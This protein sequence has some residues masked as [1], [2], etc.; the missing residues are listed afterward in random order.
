MEWRGNLRPTKTRSG[1]PALPAKQRRSMYSEGSNVDMDWGM[2][3]L[4]SLAGLQLLDQPDPDVFLEGVCCQEAQC[5]LHKGSVSSCCHEDEVFSEGFPPPVPRK[6]LVRAMSMPEGCTPPTAPQR[7]PRPPVSGLNKQLTDLQCFDNPLY[8]LSPLEGAISPERSEAQTAATANPL[9]SSDPSSDTT[10]LSQLSFDTPDEQVLP[11]LSSEAAGVIIAQRHLLF[12]RKAADALESDLLM[13][14]EAGGLSYSPEDFQLCDG[15]EPRQIGDDVY[16]ELHC[17]KFP[18]KVLGARVY[19]PDNHSAHSVPQSPH[20]NLRQVL[21]N[22]SPS[23]TQEAAAQP[24]CT[25][26]MRPLG[27]SNEFVD[28]QLVSPINNSPTI[29]ELLERG[30]AVSVERDFPQATLG[31][32]FQGRCAKQTSD[33]ALYAKQLCLLLLQVATG[34]QPLC[35]NGAMYTELRPSDVFLVWPSRAPAASDRAESRMDIERDAGEDN[36]RAAVQT[37]WERIGAPRVVLNNTPYRASSKHHTVAS[38]NTQIGGLILQGL[39]SV[40][41]GSLPK[42]T[43]DPYTERLLDLAGWLQDESAAL[44]LSRTKTILQALLWGPRAE[45]FTFHIG[46]AT[47]TVNSW[48]TISRSLLVLKMAERGLLQAGPPMDWEACL[49]LRYFASCDA[50]ELSS[51]SECLALLRKL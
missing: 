20:V 40:K 21:I 1:P 3:G 9:L 30:H 37:H 4:P 17:N 12:L 15:Y 45:L 43:S 23:R 10:P 34:L 26:P 41:R 38:T 22:F 24:D 47:S 25:P 11:Y 44:P 29:I 31:D 42:S 18:N 19:N 50:E 5:P 39:S 35:S 13:L 2:V 16:I 14:G 46:S 48:L 8:M 6:K 36:V 51:A 33:P 27:G 32:F 49:R 7:P 28:S